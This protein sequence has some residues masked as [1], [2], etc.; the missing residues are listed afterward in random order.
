[1]A[2]ILTF[3]D[4]FH[5]FHD[6][7][8]KKGK[9]KGEKKLSLHDFLATNAPSTPAQTTSVAVPKYNW[10]DECEEDDEPV[11][12]I[13]NLPTAPRSARMFD[14]EAIPHEG[15]FSVHV[16]NL[17]FD[18]NEEDIEEF[19][20]KHNVIVKEMRLPRDDK[21]SDRLRGFG[22]VEF[23]TREDLIDAIQIPDPLIHGRRIR[24]DLSSDNDKQRGNNRGGYNNNYNRGGSDN[25]S[26]NWRDRKDNGFDSGDRGGERR[27]GAGG[28]GGYGNNRS[29]NNREERDRTGDDTDWRGGDRPVAESPPP[30]RRRQAFGDRGRDG[31]RGGERRPYNRRERTPEE[32]QERPKMI[33]APRTLPLPELNFPKE[34]EIDGRKKSS[35][36]GDNDSG[37]VV[38]DEREAPAPAKPKPSAADIFGQAKPVDTA[39][40]ERIIEERLEQ[41][42]LD[43][44][45]MLEEKRQKDKEDREAKDEADR[46]A[47]LEEKTVEP[48]IIPTFKPDIV[49]HLKDH[50]DDKKDEEVNSWRKRDEGHEN[51]SES[52]KSERDGG[53][54]HFSP[55]RT[56]NHRRDDDRER[57]RQ[58][59]KDNNNSDGRGYR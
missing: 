4:F 47:E 2:L 57:P 7:I 41:E 16:T 56:M 24:I 49:I 28:G 5:L 51:G 10:A 3:C 11:R 37:V 59:N 29:Y 17:P 42:R 34:D 8:G 54:R 9:K 48:E 55:R 40:R 27:G 31:D 26:T 30:E 15:P 18:L 46:L 39:A 6:K 20:A 19:F 13:I 33:I 52:G 12:Q 36:N 44:I 14:D 38:E 45:K 1:M 50:K 43:K 22:H 21:E 35:L 58:S 23:E 25:D 53:R 32:P